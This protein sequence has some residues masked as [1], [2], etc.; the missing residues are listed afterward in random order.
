MVRTVGR[1]AIPQHLWP[2][3]LFSSL[4]RRTVPPRLR[5]GHLELAGDPPAPFDAAD[6]DPARRTG[7]DRILIAPS[8]PLGIEALPE[9]EELLDAFH[10]G[11]LELGPPFELWGSAR[12]PEV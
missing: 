2:D 1:A 5:N 6:H 10:R 9:A 4:A 3:E 8:L 11:I 12:T 7:F